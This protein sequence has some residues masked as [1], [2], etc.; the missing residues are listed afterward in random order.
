M[1]T[2][3]SL[4]NTH[5][6]LWHSLRFRVVVIGASLILLIFGLIISNTSRVLH[7]AAEEN[8]EATIRQASE[9]LNLAISPYTDAEGLQEL[10]DYFAELVSGEDQ[11]IVYLAII[12][13][14][15]RL[16]LSTDTTP[17]PLPPPN[18]QLQIGNGIVHVAQPLLLGESRVGSLRYGMSSGLLRDAIDRILKE[19]LGLIMAGLLSVV[20]VVA[21][22]GIRFNERLTRLMDASRT[23]ADGNYEIRAPAVGD[24]ELSDLARHFN[25]MAEAVETRIIDLERNRAEI[26]A[27]NNTLERRV[28]ERTQQLAQRNAELG[29]ALD[30]LKRTQQELIRSEKLA[31]L[32]A[33]VA[34]VAHELNTPIGNAL[35]VATAFTE[36]VGKFRAESEQGLR[37][38]ALQSF[39]E[40][41][42]E[43]TELVERNL[44]RASELITNFKHVAVDQ[45]SSKR[46]EFDLAKV[47]DEV[48]STLVPTFKRTAYELETELAGGL[49]M[50]S[51]PGP[52]GQVITNFVNNSLL[53]AFDGRDQG[54]MRLVCREL[55]AEHVEILFSDDG[56]GIPADQ[57]NR[58][59]DPFYTSRL[60]TGGSGLGLHIVYNIVTGLL[61]GKISVDSTPG[62]GTTFSVILP[63]NAPTS[64][65]SEPS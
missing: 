5:I 43:A 28:A 49:T 2:F 12:D 46:R 64:N 30:E 32:G 63:R 8:I 50:D 18:H 36:K 29:Q 3:L 11:G 35:T 37:R 42:R 24:D 40:Q 20:A 31:S 55:D 45:I 21:L 59:F 14:N 44:E 10:G 4:Q 13:E 47:L 25:T 17:A 16:L 51:Y 7:V 23:L 34:A 54:V 65:S 22:F 38:S 62:S 1:L 39:H 9:I 57:I 6:A 19:N 52:L 60:G 26:R 41:A 53:H 56:S 48:L 58:I 33:L 15:G 27:L 61:G